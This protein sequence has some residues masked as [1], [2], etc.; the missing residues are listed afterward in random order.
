MNG[1]EPD[2]ANA[3]ASALE[4]EPNRLPITPERMMEDIAT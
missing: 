3:I 1:P 4:Y 2:I